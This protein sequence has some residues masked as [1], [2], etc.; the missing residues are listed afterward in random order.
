VA[1]S[2]G[3]LLLD[4]LARVLVRAG[5]FAVVISLVG[6]LAFLVVEVAPL[7]RGASVSEPR[8]LAAAA[9]AEP[10]VLL[11]D[12][13]LAR[14]ASVARN[15]VVTVL[16]PSSGAVA[17]TLQTPVAGE[18]V[19]VGDAPG[20][21]TY[22][23][24]TQDGRLVVLPL[25]WL[26]SYGDDGESRAVTAAFGDPVELPLEPGDARVVTFSARARATGAAAAAVLSDG[27]LAVVRRSIRVNDFT[28]ERDEQTV[29]SQIAAPEGIAHLA[30]D[31]DQR[32]LYGASARVGAA[33]G[34]RAGV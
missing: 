20:E 32:Q 17:Q 29:R 31:S 9:G 4:R 14:L 22:T 16:D 27:T 12:S 1:T 26:V 7:F 24:L 6:I 23:A 2:R 30:L 25:D 3:R 10:A 33:S 15:G 13:S 19:A 34:R 5:G 11:V 28:G 21:S 8:V 18:V